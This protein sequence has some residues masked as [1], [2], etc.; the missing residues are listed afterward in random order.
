MTAR[1]ATPDDAAQL[2]RLIMGFRATQLIF[3]AAKLRIADHLA[4]RPLT[5]QALAQE[6]G[7]E[8]QALYRLLRALSSLGVFAE[9]A[10]G[11]FSPTALGALL[12]ADHP[13]S[14]RDIAA[15][16]GDGFMWE[17][18]GQTLHS[19][20]TGEP[21]FA[22]AH[23]ERFYDYLGGHADAAR[24]FN[25]AMSGFSHQES[26]A[27]IGAYDFSGVSSVVDIGGGQ[28][29]LVRA[30]LGAHPHLSGVVFDL[31]ATVSKTRTQTVA[32]GLQF[33]G[34]D[35]FVHVPSG[36]DVYLLKSVIHNWSDG[37]AVR[38]L[39]T[40]R[41]AMTPAAR[42]L[43]IERVIPDGGEPSEAKLFDINMLVTVGGKE[44]SAAE[45]GALFRAADFELTRVVPTA[46]PLSLI[47]ARPM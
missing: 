14:L 29:E 47:E 5:A 15:L 40:C 44:R 24:L 21:G 37:D 12:C 23:G 2:G 3:V 22:R 20:M 25:T 34:G 10:D 35:F 9:G 30:L 8:P 41:K 32:K 42:L 11:T 43:V 38:I 36:G 28:G 46:S 4:H 6:T 7:A 18:Y 45:Y 33:A 19:V 1:P 26:A 16:Y 27:I 13:R 31:P 39:E 17:A